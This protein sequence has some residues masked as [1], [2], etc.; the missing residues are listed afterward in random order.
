MLMTQS[1]DLGVEDQISAG[2]GVAYGVR[3]EFRVTGAWGK[4][5]HRGRFKEGGKSL[6]GFLQGRRGLENAG[7]C[8]D[9][10]EF[11]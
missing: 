3:E 11:A 4:D 8:D 7:M 9:P 1:S 10:Q 2:S 5:A 6:E